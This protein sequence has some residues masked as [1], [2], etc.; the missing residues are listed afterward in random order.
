MKMLFVLFVLFVGFALAGPVGAV[1]LG[2]VWIVGID[3]IGEI[4]GCLFGKG[5]CG[6]KI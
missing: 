2:L 5:D 3:I 1:V 6:G 4:F